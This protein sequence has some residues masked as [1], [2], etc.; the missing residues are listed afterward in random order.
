M[1]TVPPVALLPAEVKACV[2]SRRPDED[3]GWLTYDL[4]GRPLRLPVTHARFFPEDD[5]TPFLAALRRLAAEGWERVET[6]RPRPGLWGAQ[7]RF[8]FERPQ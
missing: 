6:I 3:I 8:R 4:N 5:E 7:L 2:L 1:N